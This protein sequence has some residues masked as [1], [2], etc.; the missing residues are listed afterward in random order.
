MKDTKGNLPNWDNLRVLADDLEVNVT[1]TFGGVYWVTFTNHT[2][3]FFDSF[4]E[5]WDYLTT[6]KSLPY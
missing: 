2:V 6:L 5:V 3:R 4:T 1:C